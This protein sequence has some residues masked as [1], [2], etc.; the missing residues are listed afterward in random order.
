VAIASA[1]VL[2]FALVPAGCKPAEPNETAAP[3]SRARGA[4]DSAWK[5]IDDSSQVAVPIDESSEAMQR[6]IARARETAESAMRRW[7]EATDDDRPYWA[8]KWAAP[9]A[10]GE[11]EYLWVTPLHWSPFR[12]EG[13]L[14]NPPQ[15]ELRDGAR[16]G[17]MVSFPAEQLVDWVHFN[18]QRLDG[19]REGGFSIDVLEERFGPAEAGDDDE[20]SANSRVDE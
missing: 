2:G 3:T 13:R 7:R 4:P 18:E 12:V 15:R 1:A 11:V 19:P 8:I 10:D 14:A 9:T 16:L 17:D 20:S 5:S 6:A